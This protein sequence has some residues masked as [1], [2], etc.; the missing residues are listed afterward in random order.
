MASTP[1]GYPILGQYNAT[2]LTRTGP[3]YVLENTLLP[4]NVVFCTRQMRIMYT[5]GVCDGCKTKPCF[6]SNTRG[7]PGK[8]DKPWDSAIKHAY[9]C[10]MLCVACMDIPMS[11]SYI[12]MPHHACLLPTN[13]SIIPCPQWMGPFDTCEIYPFLRHTWQPTASTLIYWDSNK[14]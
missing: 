10:L 5:F 3:L 9:D 1:H 8:G 11:P 2:M 12:S 6:H 14:V 7:R 13:V 4:C